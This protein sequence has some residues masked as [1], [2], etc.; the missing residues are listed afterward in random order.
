MK[1]RFTILI[2]DRNPHVRD[3]LRREMSSAGHEVRLAKN[4]REV[5][6]LVYG[7]EPLD[8]AVIDPELP[9][10]EGLRLM[11]KLE[12]RIPTL[13]LVI[14]G[15]ASDDSPFAYGPTVVAIVEK[16]GNSVERLKKIISDRLDN[17][18][19]KGAASPLQEG[20]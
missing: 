8:I 13:P 17:V 5:L 16:R 20:L 3:F 18:A 1:N 7:P 2:A 11:Q 9:E 19:E 6:E 12:D 15:F 4:A 10:L 14:H